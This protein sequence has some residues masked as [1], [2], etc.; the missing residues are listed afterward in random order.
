MERLPVGAAVA[1]AGGPSGATCDPWTMLER[2]GTGGFGNV[3][4]YQHRV[5]LGGRERERGGAGV[6]RRPSQ[7]VP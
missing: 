1:L 5:R 4:L 2:L 6:A 3:F 7:A